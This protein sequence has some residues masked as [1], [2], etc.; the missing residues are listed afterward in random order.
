MTGYDLPN[1]YI[2]NLEAL[3]R[4]K[5]SRTTPSSITPL[6]DELVTPAPSTTPS[7]AKTLRD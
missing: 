3:L 2:E 1:N 4:K 6:T 7:I 5:W